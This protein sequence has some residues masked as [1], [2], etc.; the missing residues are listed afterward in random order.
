M[1]AAIRVVAGVFALLWALPGFGFVDLAVTVDPDPVWL[2][3]AILDGGWGLLV[4]GFIV[5]ALVL[6]ALRPAWAAEIAAQL[7]GVAALIAVSAVITGEYTVWW[8]LLALILPAGALAGLA[9]L[10]RRRGTPRP[11]PA[12]R[13]DRAW[14]RW[15]Y[16]ALAALGAVP[17]LAY[18][19]EMYRAKWEGR[20]PGE[21]T[22]NVNHWAI[23]GALGVALVGFAILAATRPSLRRFN[24]VRVGLCAAYLGVCSLRFPE[25]AGGLSPAWSALAI[26]W[27]VAL[28][29]VATVPRRPA[30]Y[31]VGQPG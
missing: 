15:A 14:V 12:S 13:P 2:P 31:L 11:A 7:A 20:P 3:V 30:G 4:T 18:A 10:G 5:A 1:R 26:A 6:V 16:A 17:W 27:G 28:L 9:A 22:N 23:Q 8:M 25:G 19:V 29:V 24:A 21:I